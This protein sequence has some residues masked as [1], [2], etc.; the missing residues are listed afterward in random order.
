MAAKTAGTWAVISE[1]GLNQGINDTS[2]TQY[3]DLGKRV[4][5]K[6]TSTT[7]AYGWGE[8]IYLKGVGSTVRGSLV[9]IKDDYSTSLAAARDK[10]AL[11]VAMG[12]HAST[13]NYGWYQIKGTGVIACG[14][15]AANAPCYLAGSGTV[16][17]AVVA[18]DQVLG[19]RT[20]TSDDTST[21]VVTMGCNPATGDFDNA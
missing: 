1:I 4:T 19:M 14:T 17:D 20:K 6:D 9:L 2:T 5:A 12:A 7:T 21:C 3:Y 15:V 13:S 10:G 18:G 11:A 16:D 8:F